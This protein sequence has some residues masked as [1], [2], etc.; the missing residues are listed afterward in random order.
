M[1]RDSF[2]TLWF[3]IMHVVA[4][5]MASHF[6]MGVPFDMVSEA[7]REKTEDGPWHRATEALIQ[8]QVFRFTTYTARFGAIM[9]GVSA[10]LNSVLLTL[11]TLG[12]LEFARAMLTLFLPLTVI[13]VVTVRGALAIR[14]ADLRGDALLLKVK[15][16]RLVNQLIG[17][18]GVSMAVILAIFEAYRNITIWAF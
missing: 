12:D 9:V 17:L 13:Y 11:A 18:L 10:F 6:T 5:S 14:R 16:M 8:A 3:W 7:Q 15:R 4:W 1:D 2:W